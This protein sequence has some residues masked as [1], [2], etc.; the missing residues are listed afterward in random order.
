MLACKARKYVEVVQ[1]EEVSVIV[2]GWYTWVTN[3]NGYDWGVHLEKVA[4]IQVHKYKAAVIGLTWVQMQNETHVDMGLNSPLPR[5]GHCL[6][7]TI[8]MI[9]TAFLTRVMKSPR[10]ELARVYWYTTQSPQV[11]FLNWQCHS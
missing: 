4:V 5:G 9:L 3:A 10:G 8:A 2:Y 6:P 11:Q 1:A 7:R